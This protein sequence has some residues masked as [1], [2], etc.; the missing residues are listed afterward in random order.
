MITICNKASEINWDPLQND[1]IDLYANNIHNAVF[2]ITSE[3]IPSKEIKVKATDPPW[4][5]SSLK[6]H[7]RKRKRAYKRAKRS[8]FELE[9]RNFKHLRKTVVHMIREA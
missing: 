3:C 4:I 7:I 2:E 8:A 1:D 9:W 5:T 6:R